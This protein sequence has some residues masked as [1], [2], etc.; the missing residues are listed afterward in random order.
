MK[1][2]DVDW[3]YALLDAG[4]LTPGYY[5]EFGWIGMNRPH[6]ER[7]TGKHEA[8]AAYHKRITGKQAAAA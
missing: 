1:T 6:Y 2:G 3:F 4:A 7:I 5:G 8:T